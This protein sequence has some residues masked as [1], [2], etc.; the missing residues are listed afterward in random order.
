MRSDLT[1]Q[2]EGSERL[3]D[4]VPVSIEDASGVEGVVIKFRIQ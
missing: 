3:R 2:R 4:V 1:Q